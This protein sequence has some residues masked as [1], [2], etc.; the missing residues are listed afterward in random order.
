MTWTPPP[1]LF[2][3]RS[4]PWWLLASLV[5][6]V[7][8]AVLLLPPITA[9]A[10][11]AG[12]GASPQQAIQSAP[13]AFVGTVTDLSS[14]GRVATVR[15]DDIWRGNNIPSSV[16]VVGSPDLN[17]AATSVD[18]MYVAGAQ[19][20]FVPDGGG[21]QSFTD[22]SCTATQLFTSGLSALRPASAPGAPPH[23]ASTFPVVL[24]LVVPLIVLVGA[25]SALL[26][27]RRRRSFPAT[28]SARSP[29]HEAGRTAASAAASVPPDSNAK[30]AP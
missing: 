9:E 1:S 5:P 26:L 10:S 3:R 19:Y 28:R 14:G 23:S 18:R 11:C 12:G 27:R 16:E 30:P 22:N 29:G 21:P 6:S 24:A 20:L 13:T 4:K 25:G 7:A 17:A 2:R 8:L 15:V